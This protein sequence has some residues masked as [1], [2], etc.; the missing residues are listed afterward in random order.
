MSIKITLLEKPS[1]LKPAIHGMRNPKNS[2]AR[3]DSYE[4][5]IENP[6]TSNEAPFEFF[7]GEKDLELM[8]SLARGGSVHAK[9]RRFINVYLDLEAPLY[10]WKEFDTYRVGEAPH[11]TD[12]EMNS[13]STMHKITEKEFTLA[14]FATEHLLD[15]TL[16]ANIVLANGEKAQQ[17]VSALGVLNL[18]I[19]IL[20]YY[21]K[22]YIEAE[23]STTAKIYWWQLIQLLPSSYIQKR[24]LMLNYETLSNM[25][26]SRHDHK[27]DEWRIFCQFIETLPYSEIITGD[28][29]PVTLDPVNAPKT[30]KKK[31]KDT[32][33]HHVS[34]HTPAENIL[35]GRIDK[36]LKKGMKPAA[37]AEAVKQPVE[38]VREVIKICKDA[39]KRRAEIKKL[40][41]K[42]VSTKDIAKKFGLSESTVR[43]TLRG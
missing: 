10:W 12:L 7:V 27:Q 37:I 23:D 14:D 9:Y 32:D 11:P 35:V 33:V 17:G 34:P 30:G 41:K 21:R 25:Y 39:D 8:K 3:S 24:T 19:C 22:K 2:W 1:G 16:T 29:P 26:E 4:T 36:M 13:C 18:T 40:H 31:T 38:K 15:E 20:N 28:L 5:H 43:R 6:E 42:G